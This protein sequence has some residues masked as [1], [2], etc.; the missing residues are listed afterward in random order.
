M[1]GALTDA[2]PYPWLGLTPRPDFLVAMQEAYE[3][4]GASAAGWF[5]VLD[6]DRLKR[7]NDTF[8]LPSG[9]AV[10]AR[11]ARTLKGQCEAP[12]LTA[13][14]GG[15]EFIA[16]YPGADEARARVLAERLR[17]AF[18]AERVPLAEARALT[19]PEDL[20]DDL[21]GTSFTLSIGLAPRLPTDEAWQDALCRAEHALGEAKNQ[22][23]DRC[24][25]ETRPRPWADPAR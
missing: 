14:Y 5:L 11:V 8:G 12:A 3:A 10:L 16:W 19:H 22:G 25:V 9:D 23:R 7:I 17:L 20:A 6:V 21:A 24:L 4:G 1:G 18:A 13:R 2:E 15:E